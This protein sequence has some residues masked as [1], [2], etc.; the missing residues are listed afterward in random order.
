MV[1]RRAKVKTG[2]VR[3]T[4]THAVETRAWKHAYTHMY[5]RAETR[6]STR[7]HTYTHTYTHTHVYVRVECARRLK[8]DEVMTLARLA[9]TLIETS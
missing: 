8:R 6:R 1:V 5:T 3:Y 2:V 4:H 7:A 9:R